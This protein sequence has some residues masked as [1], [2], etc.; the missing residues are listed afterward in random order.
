[1]MNPF[2]E[3]HL[4]LPVLKFQQG[5]Y[6][7]RLVSHICNLHRCVSKAQ[8]SR[9]ITPRHILP[10]LQ[11]STKPLWLCRYYQKIGLFARKLCIHPLQQNFHV[12]AVVRPPQHCA[13]FCPYL[14]S[15]PSDWW[16]LQEGGCRL[17]KVPCCTALCRRKEIRVVKIWEV[18]RLLFFTTH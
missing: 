8:S 4:N 18:L 3:N 7:C 15:A 17:T 16:V 5:L 9:S 6:F 2:I 10:G 1:M 14:C 11:E 13:T 12:Y